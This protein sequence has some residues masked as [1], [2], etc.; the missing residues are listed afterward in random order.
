MKV[1]SLCVTLNEWDYYYLV[2]KQFVEFFSCFFLIYFNKQLALCLAL[3]GQEDRLTLDFKYDSLL[4]IE[5][6]VQSLSNRV[7]L[8][9][10]LG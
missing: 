7:A 8:K 3:T 1:Q 10:S 6:I 4:K 9:R 5:V 2:S